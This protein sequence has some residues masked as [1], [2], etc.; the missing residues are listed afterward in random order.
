L[1]GIAVGGGLDN[2]D[3]VA[4]RHELYAAAARAAVLTIARL[5]ASG[6]LTLLASVPT[7]AG[8]RNA[9]ATDEGTAYV[10]DSAD[11]K[12]LVVSPTRSTGPDL[13]TQ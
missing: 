8:A 10:P 9:V 2:I 12:L 5:D 1:G 6:A 11:G 4:T 7:A 3:Y 13:R